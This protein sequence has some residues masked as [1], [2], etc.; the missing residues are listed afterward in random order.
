MKRKTI[1]QQL[2]QL[3]PGAKNKGPEPASAPSG[4]LELARRGPAVTAERPTAEELS[5]HAA[6]PAQAATATTEA[7]GPSEPYQASPSATSAGAADSADPVV[8]T[9]PQEQACPPLV[10][11]QGTAK[12]GFCLPTPNSL[13]SRGPQGARAVMREVV[14]TMNWAPSV[15]RRYVEDLVTEAQQEMR[16]LNEALAIEKA[17]HEQDAAALKRARAELATT[18]LELRRV[19]AENANLQCSKNALRKQRDALQKQ[20]E[21]KPTASSA[22]LVQARQLAQATSALTDTRAQLELAQTQVATLTF[23]NDNLKTRLSHT[24]AVLDAHTAAQQALR[25]DEAEEGQPPA[26]PAEAEP[27]LPTSLVCLKSWAQEHLK[28]KL[29]IRPKALEHAM[30]SHYEQPQTVYR[31][32]LLLANEYRDLKLGRAKHNWVERLAQ[33]Q[34]GDDF[35]LAENAPAR[36]REGHT[37]I[38]EGK[39]YYMERHLKKGNSRDPRQC[40]RIYYTWDPEKEQV[41]VGALP[42]HLRT[43]QT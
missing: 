39:S 27:A 33:L 36:M 3:R 31:A 11:A 26:P 35:S 32:L 1:Q 24:Q 16:R 9:A 43:R 2:A 14:A 34:L 28:G 6:G 40:L 20:L 21:Q 4:S 23:Q 19:Q 42:E 25:E 38:I 8:F 7:L 12:K 13:R 29:T 5:A 41:I 30:Q 37:F 15:I 10:G 17:A 22:E 18:Q